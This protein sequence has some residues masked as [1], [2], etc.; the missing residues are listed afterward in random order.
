[1]GILHN[2]YWYWW[3]LFTYTDR[4]RLTAEGYIKRIKVYSALSPTCYIFLDNSPGCI[5]IKV[6][7]ATEQAMKQCGEVEIQLHSF[8]T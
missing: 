7:V 4:Y 5:W 3:E 6:K 1:M 8:L 2:A